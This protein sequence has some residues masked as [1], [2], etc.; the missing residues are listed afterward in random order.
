MPTIVIPDSLLVSSAIV[1]TIGVGMLLGLA[2]PQ[3]M[4]RGT[5]MPPPSRSRQR[6]KR[7]ID[8]ESEDEATEH[9][10]ATLAPRRRQERQNSQEELI[11]RLLSDMSLRQL[12]AVAKGPSMEEVAHGGSTAMM[13]DLCNSFSSNV[14]S[15]PRSPGGAV[16]AAEVVSATKAGHASR[17]KRTPRQVLL[18]LQRGNGRFWMGRSQRPELN[19]MERRAL[20]I[21]QA[22]SVCVL[23]C[24]DSRVPV[25]IIFDQGLGDIFVV[26][27]AG[28]VLDCSS[29]GSIE[30]AVKHLDVKVVMVLGHEG[31]GAVRGAMG[32]SCSDIDREPSHLKEVLHGIRDQLP[33]RHLMEIQDH[34]ARDREAVVSC[35]SLQMRLLMETDIIAQRVAEGSLIVCGAFYEITSG[36]VDFFSLDK[37]GL[38]C[39]VEV[40]SPCPTLKKPPFSKS[41]AGRPTRSRRSPES[42]GQG[43]P[44]LPLSPLVALDSTP[45]FGPS[46]NPVSRPATTTAAA[47]AHAHAE[48][49]L[50]FLTAAGR[51]VDHPE[52]QPAAALR[53]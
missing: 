47:F 20:I 31:C 13:D 39:D 18:D 29:H 52:P 51:L 1:A 49:P 8:R 9:S 46:T 26:R 36:I 28:N 41:K 21:A 38:L 30:Y 37:D 34:R 2:L 10:P 27:V 16:D 12:R 6:S 11:Q 24:S 45:G 35:S 22:P 23:G 14:F 44:L 15:P 3:L 43:S 42:Q 7:S 19:A 48:E 40:D 50:T 5:T 4:N 33:M 32:M 17:K 25:E 53:A